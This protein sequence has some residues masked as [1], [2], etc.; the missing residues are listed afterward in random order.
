MSRKLKT[1]R[2]RREKDR[3]LVLNIITSFI[4]GFMAYMFVLLKQYIL[5]EPMLLTGLVEN[6]T[7]I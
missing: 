4:A 5:A 3:N 7:T 2:R 1:L 6:L